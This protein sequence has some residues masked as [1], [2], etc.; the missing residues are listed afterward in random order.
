MK[1]YTKDFN[2]AHN[3]LTLCLASYTVV[4]G[5]G[6]IMPFF[7]LYASN[8]LSEIG[9]G[10]FTIGIAL[11]IGIMT[12][13]FMFTRFLLAP[14]FGDLS[15][16][17]GRKPL[18]LVG[19]S[20]YGVLMVGFGLA[21][22]FPTLFLLRAA[23]G[24][25]SAAVWPVGEALIVDTS[26]K[27]KVGR[28]LGYYMMSMQA[29]MASGPFIGFAFYFAFHEIIEFSEV[30]SYKLTFISVGVLGF[31]ATAIVAKM[32]RDPS[33]EKREESLKGLY[34]ASVIAMT[35]KTRGSPKFLLKSLNN[36]K[37]R[38][39]RNRSIYTIYG[40]AVI[41]GF[42]F[43]MIF[44]IIALFAYDYYNLDPGAI[45]LLIGLVGLPALSGGPLGGHI[46]DRIGRK[47]TICFSG[48]VVGTVF[49]LIGIEMAIPLLMIL[50]LINRFFFGVIQP[51]FRA[52]QSDMVP[53]EVR[54]KEFGILQAFF[55][56]GSSIGPIAGGLLY[57]VFFMKNIQLTP[58]L[59]YFG[60]GMA[61]A[62]AGVLALAAT[63]LLLILVDYDRHKVIE[64][65]ESD[66]KPFIAIAPE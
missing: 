7:P 28:N 11:Q 39:Y 37:D 17:A 8:V 21:Y 30:L 6:V 58:S 36:H 27:E 49:L 63:F 2:P 42:G 32:V 47:A 46:S 13:A 61:F 29:G 25:A 56:L 53:A 15:D 66:F 38:A 26:P 57:D 59:T 33:I 19:M 23:Q 60:A 14:S 22:D 64:P 31:A 50:F 4:T 55:N 20:I 54:G 16:S 51:S 65:L 44:P 48:F 3:L 24:V 12:S 9:F 41:N 40:V 34:F 10:F 62:L 35:K 52:L 5:F 45:A 1:K 43:A 18:I